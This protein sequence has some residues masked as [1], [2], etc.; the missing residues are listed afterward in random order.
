MG[1][2]DRMK[3]F[4]KGEKNFIR[5][6]INVEYLEPPKCKISGKIKFTKKEA[7]SAAISSNRREDY[8][9]SIYKCPDCKTWHRTKSLPS[10]TDKNKHITVRG[11]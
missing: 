4:L 6:V 3:R 8:D 7:L 2:K 1:K 10:D 11:K 5:I 9:I